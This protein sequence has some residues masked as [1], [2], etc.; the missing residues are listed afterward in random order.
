MFEKEIDEVYELCKKVSNE[1]PTAFVSFEYTSRGLHVAG[2]KKENDIYV[3]TGGDFHWDVFCDIYH[4]PEL[5]S[6]SRSA[7]EHIKSF[8]LE[9]LIDGKCPN[10]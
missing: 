6:I 1:V 9:L 7:Y 5:E 3:K 10:E 8:L 4:E 2:I